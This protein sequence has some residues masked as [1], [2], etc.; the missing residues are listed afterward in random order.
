MPDV[1]VFLNRHV[2]LAADTAA[3]TTSCPARSAF[4]CIKPG[5]QQQQQ[6]LLQRV[7]L[8]TN[9]IAQ[10][11]LLNSRRCMSTVGGTSSQQANR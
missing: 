6:Q 9:R 5:Q 3:Q 1:D 2:T 7:L 8:V 11:P 10:R 4:K